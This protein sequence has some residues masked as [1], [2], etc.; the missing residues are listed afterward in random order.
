MSDQLLCKRSPSA[1][2]ESS[3]SSVSTTSFILRHDR[4]ATLT[5]DAFRKID[6]DQY[7]EDVLLDSE[8]YEADS[9]DPATVLSE[10]KQKAST[11]RGLLSKCVLSSPHRYRVDMDGCVVGET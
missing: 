7:D 3:L 1:L 5:M 10:T 11:I 2:P 4:H 8:L 9:R 6:I